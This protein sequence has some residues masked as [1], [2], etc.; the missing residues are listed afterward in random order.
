MYTHLTK[1]K[2]KKLP[3]KMQVVFSEKFCPEL[4]LLFQFAIEVT[5]HYNT[6][7]FNETMIVDVPPNAT[8]AAGSQVSHLIKIVVTT[9][10]FLPA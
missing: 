1:Y 9:L 5:V 4:K 7:D 10:K 3:P 2:P 8:V 6:K